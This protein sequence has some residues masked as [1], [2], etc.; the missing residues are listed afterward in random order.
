VTTR[1]VCVHCGKPYGYR[2][3][4]VENVRWPLGT[5]CPAYK[6][7]GIVLSEGPQYKTATRDAMRGLTMM[8]VNPDIRARQEVQLAELP[9]RSEMVTSRRVWDGQTWRGGYTPFCT[10]RCALSYA[11][12]A[13]KRESKR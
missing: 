10:L 2:E 13:Y 11:R 3:V 4:T 5:E 8:S 9:E 6:G 12:A 1:P 7:N